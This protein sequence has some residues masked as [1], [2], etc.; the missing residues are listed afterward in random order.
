M[1]GVSPQFGGKP[2]VRSP[3]EIASL[4]VA[5]ANAE[6]YSEVERGPALNSLLTIA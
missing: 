2:I 1:S 5:V 4:A 6:A 3:L